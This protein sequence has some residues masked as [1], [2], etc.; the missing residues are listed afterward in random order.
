MLADAYYVL[1]D[2]HDFNH[3]PKAAIKSYLRSI[4]L[5]SSSWAWRELGNM[6][7]NMGNRDKAIECLEKALTIDPDDKDAQSDLEDI[8]DNYEKPLFRQGD[9]FWTARELLSEDRP[10]EAF[11]LIKNKKGIKSRLYRARIFGA[12][13]KKDDYLKEWKNI[14]K[15]KSE[16]ELTWADWFYMPSFIWDFAVFWKYMIEIFPRLKSGIN[17]YH[18]S[19]IMNYSIF[20]KE[21][22]KQGMESPASEWVFKFNYYRCMN[23][24]VQLEKL[25]KQFPLWKEPKLELKKLKKDIRETDTKYDCKKT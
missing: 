17:I 4:E 13:N 6:Y 10:D 21:H 20:F 8:K 15:M 9:I 25:H 14:S 5:D 18:E 19:L 24:I 23:D 3:A 12:E 11:E 16:F 1:G 7:A 2:I 22:Q